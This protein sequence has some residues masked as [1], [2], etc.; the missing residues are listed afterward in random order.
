MDNRLSFY[1]QRLG[2]QILLHN[3]RF[4]RFYWRGEKVRISA[5]EQCHWCGESMASLEHVL[6][7]CTS[8]ATIRAG[9]GLSDCQ[10]PL[11]GHIGSS[12]QLTKIIMFTKLIW[13]ILVERGIR[14]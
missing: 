13:P 5:E 10:Q 9:M 1:E 14:S 3:V 4:T 12:D 6:L 7:R 8:L 11:A 2:L